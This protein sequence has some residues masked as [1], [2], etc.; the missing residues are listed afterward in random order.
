MEQYLFHNTRSTPDPR[1]RALQSFHLHE[2]WQV[3]FILQ[4]S[5]VLNWKMPTGT[6]NR[7]PFEGGDAVIIPPGTLHQFVYEDRFNDLL[8]VKF[9][10]E[11]AAGDPLC[12]TEKKIPF[13]AMQIIVEALSPRLMGRAASLTVVN[14]ALGVIMSLFLLELQQQRSSDS[15][16]VR[17]IK[18]YVYSRKGGDVRLEEIGRELSCT[19][20][21][22]SL[23]FR[24]ETGQSLKNFLDR[25]RA[26]YCAR[27]LRTSDRSL[28]DIAEQLE[29]RDLYAFSRFFRR[30]MNESLSDYRAK[31]FDSR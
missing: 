17:K 3:D 28:T 25:T 22:A 10:S 4:G 12:F 9:S 26:D 18:E 23:R 14:E 30:I 7:I 21:H 24:R 2:F 19:G 15:D 1:L 5:G 29:F 27:L 13:C 11:H 6:Q 8:S 20:K 16:F 31:R